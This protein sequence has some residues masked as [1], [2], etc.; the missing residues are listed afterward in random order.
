MAYDVP[1]RIEWIYLSPFN[2]P[3][4]IFETFFEL[5]FMSELLSFVDYGLKPSFVELTSCEVLEDVGIMIL[6]QLG[7][8]TAVRFLPVLLF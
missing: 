2:A 5:E 4:L 1:S 3:F 7:I 6:F 8:Q